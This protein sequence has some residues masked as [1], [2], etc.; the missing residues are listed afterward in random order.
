MEPSEHVVSEKTKVYVSMNNFI[1]K[2]IVYR[3]RL[4][5]QRKSVFPG[6]RESLD[7][8]LNVSSDNSNYLFFFQ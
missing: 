3:D 6:I 4:R 2:S 5:P 8:S 7:M 1:L